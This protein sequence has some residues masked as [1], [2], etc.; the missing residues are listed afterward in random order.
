[1]EAADDE[2]KV[3][4]LTKPPGKDSIS[5]AFMVK[6]TSEASDANMKVDFKD[7]IVGAS[8]PGKGKIHNDLLHTV[9]I[10]VLVNSKAI[11]ANDELIVYFEDQQAQPQKRQ[12]VGIPNV[13]HDVPKKA[14]RH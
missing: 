2:N 10:P 1:M 7:G 12:P 4:T 9:R 11:K 5:Y 3:V 13:F 6:K 8:P 14:A